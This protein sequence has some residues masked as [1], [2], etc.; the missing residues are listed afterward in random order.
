MR[1]LKCD[2]ILSKKKEL[3][4]SFKDL[5][6]LKVLWTIYVFN[7]IYFVIFGN[8]KCEKLVIPE[9]LSSVANCIRMLCMLSIFSKSTLHSVVFFKSE[10]TQ[11]PPYSDKLDVLPSTALFAELKISS[12]CHADLLSAMFSKTHNEIGLEL[13]P[14]IVKIR[15]F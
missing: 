10:F 2:L 14:G 8:C 4:L 6:G 3:D 7:L 9:T 11:S 5:E 12:S 1:L 13:N 15:I